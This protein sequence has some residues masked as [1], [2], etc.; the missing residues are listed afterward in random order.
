M[1]VI[2]LERIERLGTMGQTV[3]VRPGYA[4]NYL[5]PQKKALRATKANLELFE[6][7][8]AE[9]EAKNAT[10][11]VDA[12]KLATTMNDMKVIIIRQASEMGMLYGSVSARDVADALK[13][14]GKP[15]DRSMIQIDTPIKTLG[16]FPV[17]VK[18]HPEVSIKITVNVARSPEEAIIQAEKGIAILK[19]AEK[20][21]QEEAERAMIESIG[22]PSNEAQMIAEAEAAKEEKA[23]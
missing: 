8:R 19:A 4:R 1:E 7:Q 18:L 17:K 16:L 2:L 5:L 21:A 14:A 13:E 22:V 11:R 10:K 20:A 23:K 6:K 15:A 9:L 3:K 12:E